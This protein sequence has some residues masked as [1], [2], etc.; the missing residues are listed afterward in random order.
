MPPF[1]RVVLIVL[2]SCGLGGAPDAARYGDAGASTLP[3]VALACG[4]LRLPVMGR[5]GLGRLA[6]IE[7][8]PPDPAPQ[9]E[10]PSAA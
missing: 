9:P 7:G 10:A 8:V 5:L 2:D 1:D 3:H 6:A 4:G